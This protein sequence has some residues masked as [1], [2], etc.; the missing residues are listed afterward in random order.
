MA[1]PIIGITSRVSDDQTTSVHDA[2][3]KK[4]VQA[5]GVPLIV[6]NIND[7]TTI[8]TYVQTLDGLLLTGGP[9]VD[10]FLFGEE[11]IKK[12]GK[13]TPK[14]DFLELEITKLMYRKQKPILGIC[15]GLQILN[16]AL[17]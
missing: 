5:G 10:P 2:N 6:P 12:L 4:I 1:R 8:E 11:P 14:R 9:D 17:G 16:V 15:R 3:I 7:R 13:I